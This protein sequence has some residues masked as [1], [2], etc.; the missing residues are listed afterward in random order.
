MSLLNARF[1]STFFF[2]F[3][4]VSSVLSQRIEG[5]KEVNF[6]IKQ[7][8]SSNEAYTTV[9]DDEGF[10]WCGT[11]RGISRYNYN[12]FKSYGL[13]EGLGNLLVV[14]LKFDPLGV[15]WANCFDDGLYYYSKTEDRFIASPINRFVFGKKINTFGFTSNNKLRLSSVYALYE[16]DHLDDSVLNLVEN[17]SIKGSQIFLNLDESYFIPRGHWNAKPKDLQIEDVRE[18]DNILYVKGVRIE[19]ASKVGSSIFIFSANRKVYCYNKELSKLTKL[20]VTSRYIKYRKVNGQNWLC[21]DNGILVLGSSLERI[22]KVLFKNELVTDV[23]VDYE[24][25]IWLT[26]HSDGVVKLIKDAGF[27]YLTPNNVIADLAVINNQVF[28][29]K[30]DGVSKFDQSEIIDEFSL[31]DF[32]YRL[33]HDDENIFLRENILYNTITKKFSESY[34]N[35]ESITGVINPLDQDYLI[36]RHLRTLFKGG[37]PYEAIN[38]EEIRF[39]AYH[40]ELIG[41]MIYAASD[42][43]LYCVNFKHIGETVYLDKSKIIKDSIS[44]TKLKLHQGLLWFSTLANGLF[45]LNTNTNELHSF[46]DETKFPFAR[47]NNFCIERDFVLISTDQGVV[48]A[49]YNE[50]NQTLN[51]LKTLN[52]QNGLLSTAV[53]DAVSLKDQLY[54][55]GELG[56]NVVSLR[57]VNEAKTKPKLAISKAVTLGNLRN[58]KSKSLLKNNQNSVRIEFSGLTNFA[59]HQSKQYFVSL[60]LNGD[61]ILSYYTKDRFAQF[62]NLSSGIYVFKVKARNSSNIWSNEESFQFEIKQHFT[63]STWFVLLIGLLFGAIIFLFVRRKGRLKIK[64]LNVQR[65]IQE[66]TIIAQEAR[67]QATNAKLGKFKSQVNP[68]FIYNALNSIQNLFF[69]DKKEEA[70]SYISMFSRLLRKGLNYSDLKTILVEEEMVYLKEYLE[71]EKLRFPDKFFYEIICPDEV[72]DRELDIPPHL[73]QPLLE[74]CIKHGFIHLDE[75][76]M[77][78]VSFILNEELGCLEVEVEDN[79]V[80]IEHSQPNQNHNSKGL[81]II[82][83]HLNL[84]NQDA[85]FDSEIEYIDKSNLKEMKHGTIVRMKIALLPNDY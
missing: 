36:D 65:V 33:I 45:V 18:E 46:M 31:D 3:L 64:E 57:E 13:N 61:S 54:I 76:G 44:V 72:L 62:I 34:L 79:G 50:A 30:D 69:E 8:L 81:A 83:E 39:T 5:Y 70:N 7:G 14:D 35:V 20:D 25:V 67:L 26:L 38:E 17:S 23:L 55:V 40:A 29:L 53:I 82:Q 71:L 15:L 27:P 77:V 49:K 74:N 9:Q 22:E 75:P 47:I 63:Q 4:G 84:V 78:R 59:P 68:H 2:L 1:Y 52:A 11:D 28:L 58:F 21:T 56:I 80:G 12:E 48:V 37:T 85:S 60:F 6:T 32:H 10:I 16:Q 19:Y 41:N 66:K 43:N 24:G 42:R 51:I 73:I